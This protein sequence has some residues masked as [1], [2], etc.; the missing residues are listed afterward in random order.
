[1]VILVGQTVEKPQGSSGKFSLGTQLNQLNIL[2]F[3]VDKFFLSKLCSLFGETFW[4]MQSK[5]IF[6]EFW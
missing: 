4:E 2:C 6:R 5:G 1:M 3:A